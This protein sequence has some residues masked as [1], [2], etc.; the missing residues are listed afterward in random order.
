MDTE[1][2]VPTCSDLAK[3]C[4]TLCNVKTVRTT[5]EFCVD[6]NVMAESSAGVGS[7]S[8]DR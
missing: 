4:E 5:G 7:F 8:D 2:K 6:E 3:K 1:H